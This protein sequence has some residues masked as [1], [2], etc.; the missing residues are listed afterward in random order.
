[1]APILAMSHRKQKKTSR[2]QQ[3]RRER[4][5]LRQVGKKQRE[6]GAVETKRASITNVR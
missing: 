4:R 6:A 3:Q 1:M 2:D 5:L